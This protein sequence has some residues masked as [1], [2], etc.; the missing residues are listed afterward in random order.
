MREKEV[1]TTTTKNTNEKKSAEQ[2]KE[3]ELKTP[4]GS[5]NTEEAPQTNV[6]PNPVLSLLNGIGIFSFGVLGV[7]YALIRSEK[8]ATDAI[9]EYMKTK[10]KE[11]EAVIVSLGKSYKSNLLGEQEERSKQLA[12]AKD[13]QNSLTS[14][15]SLAKSTIASLGNELN[16]EKKLIEELKTQIDSFKTNLSKAGEEKVVL[17]ENLK[18]KQNSIEV[19][20]GMIDL[21]NS[22]IKDKENNVRSLSSSLAEKD[23]ELR[24]LKATYN[25]M[26]DELTN[27]LSDSQMLKDEL[28]K[29]QKELKLK[30]SYL[31][32]LNATISSFT[33]ELND[34]KREV[35][36][37]Q[38][39][40]NNLK[41]SSCRKAD[42]DAKLLEEREEK[43]QQLKEKL[44][45]ALSDTSRNKELNS[46]LT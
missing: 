40:Y 20:Q 18:K 33:Y 16:G 17:E 24:D 43:F 5:K 7:L 26:R 13:E 12:K 45:L 19:L 44:E 14:E 30:N 1:E 28:L 37:I 4:E 39:E 27:A 36:A 10:L 3:S 6:A 15:L 8:K 46:D 21:L 34:S 42:L 9:V 22:E 2:T 23:L 25:Q 11:K 32:E 29:N 31:D 35:D 38:E 41:T